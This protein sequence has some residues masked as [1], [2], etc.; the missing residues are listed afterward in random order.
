MDGADL[1]M[2]ALAEAMRRVLPP[3]SRRREVEHDD[4]LVVDVVARA[5]DVLVR[6]RWMGYPYDLGF[7]LDPGSA[8]A[9]FDGADDWAGQAVLLLDEELGTGLV[10]RARRH[11]RDGFIEL[12]S[13][14][15]PSDRRC[16]V[17]T[18][19]PGAD[20]GWNAVPFV[21][22][23]GLDAS[24][25]TSRRRDGTLLSWHLAHVDDVSGAPYVGH[26]VVVRLDADTALL[27][28]CVTTPGTPG[29]VTLDLCRL[30]AHS[31]SWHGARSV[32]TDLEHP[33]LG[34]LGFEDRGGQRVLDTR[35]LSVD[36]DAADRLVAA[37]PDW[38][39]PR[40]RRRWGRLHIASS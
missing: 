19:R 11:E 8:Y 33:A 40:A 26:A 28:E 10:A 27:E 34:I 20:V 38:R 29:S 5:D 17:Q 13:P 14:D 9:P 23:D 32:V 2:G 22:R 21:R 15:V 37:Q 12:T 6:F 1:P 30:A 39:P 35:F 7:A 24:V 4:T 25:A 3:G 31:A 36:H 18:V 16:Y